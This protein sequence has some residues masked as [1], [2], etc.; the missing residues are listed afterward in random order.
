MSEIRRCL[1]AA[2]DVYVGFIV[3]LYAGVLAASEVTAVADV[4]HVQLLSNC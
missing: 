4:T 3:L 1:L 2:P